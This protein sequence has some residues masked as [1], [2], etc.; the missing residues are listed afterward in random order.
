MKASPFSFRHLILKISIYIAIFYF[1]I[2]VTSLLIT[3]YLFIN[4]NNYKTRI[5]KVITKHTGYTLKV[6]SIQTKLSDYYLPA[7]TINNLVLKNA[8]EPTQNFKIKKLVLV[9][10][11]SSIWNFEPI[12]N[13]INIYNS[14]INIEYWKDG[15]I[16]INGINLNHPDKK[17]LENTKNAP[18]DLEN[19]ILKQFKINIFSTNLSFLDKKN[20]L[21]KVEFNN[22]DASLEND[23]FQKHSFVTA[24]DDLNNKNIIKLKMSWVGGKLSQW[25]KL[26][27]LE[28]K[29]QTINKKDKLVGFT[30]K[31]LPNFDILEKFNAATALNLEVKKGQLQFLTADFDIK[32]FSSLVNSKNKHFINFPKLGGS[33]N[34]K[35]IDNSHY[36]ILANNLTINTDN[37][38]VINNKKIAG[39]YYINK[40]GEIS[41][42]KTNLSSFNN[43]L[44]IFP[45]VNNLTLSGTLDIVKLNWLGN[46]FK[47]DSYTI[48]SKFNKLSVKSKDA[49]I[50][51]IDNINGDITITNTGGK[52]N[53]FLNDSTLNYNKVFLIPYKFNSLSSQ[54][55]WTINK[56]KTIDVVLAPTKIKTIDFD[57]DIQGKYKYTHGKLGYLE[58]TAHVEKILT[59]KVGDYLPKQ[60]GNSVHKWL[61]MALVG[62]YGVKGTMILK[63]GVADFPFTNGKGIFNIDAQIDNGKLLYVD[64]WPTLDNIVGKFI[65]RNQ[66]IIIQA[67]TAKVSGN[68]LKNALVV[69]PDMTAENPYLTA[70]GIGNGSTQNFMKYLKNTPVNEIIGNIPDKV[71]TKGNGLVNLHLMVPFSDPEH[72][73]VDGNYAFYDNQ[74]KFD[75][76]VPVLNKVEGKLYFTNH[77][78]TIDK[79]TAKTL[80][81]DV[82]LNAHQSKDGVIHF[83]AVSPNLDYPSLANFYTPFIVKL[84]HGRSLTNI[85]FDITLNGLSKLW[86]DSNLIGVTINA[87]KPLSKN[88]E[89]ISKLNFMLIPNGKNGFNINFDYYNLLF[90]NINI[91][92]DSKINNGKIAVGKNKFSTTNINKAKLQ[93]NIELEKTYISEWISMVESIVKTSSNNIVKKSLNDKKVLSLKKENYKYSPSSVPDIFPIEVLLSTKDLFMT[94]STLGSA[95]ANLLINNNYII[96]NFNSFRT[97]GYGKY[98]YSENKLN[99][100]LDQFRI[101][102]TKNNGHLVKKAKENKE[103]S[104][105]ESSTKIYTRV[106]NNPNVNKF[107]ESGMIGFLNFEVVNNEPTTPDLAFPKVNLDVKKLFIDNQNLGNLGLKLVPLGHDLFIESGL[108]DG[109]NVKVNFHGT[110]FCVNCNVEK[111]YVNMQFDAQIKNLGN[112]V[113]ILGY[114]KLIDKGSGKLLSTLQ[115]NGLIQDFDFKNAIG[116]I[117]VDLRSGKFLKINNTSSIFGSLLGIL[118]LQTIVSVAQLNFNNIFVSGFY[119]DDLQMHSYL[120]NNKVDIKSLNMNG[121]SASV[122]SH[123]TI[124]IGNDNVDLYLTVSPKIGGLIAVGIAVANPIAGA[125]A[126]VGQWILRGPFDKLFSFTYKVSGSLKAPKTKQIEVSKQIIKNVNNAVGNEN[127]NEK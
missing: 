70:D 5:E 108:L 50:P 125:I 97:D 1:S 47:P 4:L 49:N 10:S 103:V 85:Y 24:I 57:G 27:K 23:Y 82:V 40:R 55:N 54:I 111:S 123:G 37:G 9:F 46:I 33:I 109:D 16:V 104:A 113:E 114:G 71:E 96:F 52:L 73:K 18:I 8:A 105:P 43:L 58:L 100:Y 53:L 86:A 89:T 120:V 95:N 119:F 59:S 65:I 20:N 122:S 102:L 26:D 76:S 74:I 118:N 35:L 62:G 116:D 39:N 88:S 115:W 81:S 12:F 51:S 41:I 87:A 127:Q 28:L 107:N 61:H 112:L 7:I 2:I 77:G 94:S 83:K 56:D 29:L 6:D 99:L 106:F 126:Y 98:D 75:F 32:N 68:D 19:W 48:F 69:I 38:Y 11:Y 63:G 66:K 124:D 80:N 42:D 90:G 15:S 79:I 64:G 67:D 13:K 78:L 14:D 110:N 101:F 34:I 31:Y 36:E 93:V 44:P 22:V 72:T 21:P 117:N 60:I 17:V 25:Q 84:I 3:G 121:P 30:L 91:D 45:Y 92:A